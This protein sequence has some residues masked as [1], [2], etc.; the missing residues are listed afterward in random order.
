[1]PENDR[2]KE[3]AA[4]FKIP[5]PEVEII[6]NGESVYKP[7][8]K[9]Y[10]VERDGVAALN[11]ATKVKGSDGTVVGGT[12]CTC[13]LVIVDEA[14]G[15]RSTCSSHGIS[16]GKKSSGGGGGGGGCSCNKVCTCVPVT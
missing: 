9:S 15:E 3:E 4:N 6:V 10:F 14:T 7:G 12:I 5:K 13:N 2:V 8:M 11:D 16:S 1:M